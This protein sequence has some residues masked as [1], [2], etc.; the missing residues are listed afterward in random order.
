M[1]N[2][3]QRMPFLLFEHM[4]CKKSIVIVKKFDFEIFIYLHVFRPPEFFYANFMVMYVC[5]YACVCV[6]M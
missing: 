1:S 2:L 4:L 3:M 6:C 5:V